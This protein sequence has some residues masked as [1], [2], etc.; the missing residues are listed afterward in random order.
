MRSCLLRR[1]WRLPRGPHT[2]PERQPSHSWIAITQYLTRAKLPWKLHTTHASREPHRH[3][4]NDTTRHRLP[5]LHTHIPERYHCTHRHHT[6]GH[7]PPMTRHFTQLEQ[8]HTAM[9]LTR[10]HAPPRLTACTPRRGEVTCGAVPS[11]AERARQSSPPLSHA[12]ARAQQR[13][14]SPS[15]H[16]GSGPRRGARTV[17]AWSYEA[18]STGL[19]PGCGV[20]SEPKSAAV[21]ASASA[22]SSR[23]AASSCWRV[24]EVS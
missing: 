6:M 13:G 16:L 15:S 9:R 17:A 5:T 12:R 21:S 4:R 7:T 20:V 8:T 14:D 2:R 10:Q 3:A 23:V 11:S 22:A 19:L 1:D 24:C 18:A